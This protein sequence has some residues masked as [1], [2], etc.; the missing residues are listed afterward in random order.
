V[1]FD[2]NIMS[3]HWD[4]GYA[5][6]VKVPEKDL[7]K[8]PEDISLKLGNLTLDTIGVPFGALMEIDI[9]GDESVSVHGCGPI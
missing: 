7:L 4:G 8:L 9:K 6:Y 2:K 1:D 5:E 3:D